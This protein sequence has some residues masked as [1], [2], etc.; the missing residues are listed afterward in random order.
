MLPEHNS[1]LRF[2]RVALLREK[3]NRGKKMVG[4]L[5]MASISIKLTRIRENKW[6]ISISSNDVKSRVVGV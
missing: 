5:L 2:T 1:Q 4:I 3:K 6:G